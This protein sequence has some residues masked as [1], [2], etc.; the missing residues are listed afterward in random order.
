[1]TSEIEQ[2]S[3]S[4]SATRSRKSSASTTALI[5]GRSSRLGFE[6]ERANVDVS[7]AQSAIP[8]EDCTMIFIK[9]PKERMAD[10]KRPV[11]S[12]TLQISQLG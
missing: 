2:L 5:I 12:L 7:F 10:A 6:W 9:F 8:T 11:S 3:F 1:M 4:A